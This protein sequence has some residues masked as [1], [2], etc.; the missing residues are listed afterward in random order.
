MSQSDRYRHLYYLGWKQGRSCPVLIGCHHDKRQR[1]TRAISYDETKLSENHKEAD[2]K[3]ILHACDAAEIRYDWVLVIYRDTYV[4]LVNLMPVV[5]V[6]MIAGTAK[7]WKFN[8]VHELSQRLT[9]SVKDKLLS[10]HA[11]TDCDTTLTFSGHG[12]KSCCNHFRSTHFLSAEL[13]IMES[14][15]QLRSL[16]VTY[17]AH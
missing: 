1:P 6:W 11:L 9:Q 2:R 3:L 15:H 13:V 5:E 8:P 10:F 14:S 16:C 12:K 17:L 4:L 7:K